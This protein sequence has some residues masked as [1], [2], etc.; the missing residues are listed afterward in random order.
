MN[1]NYFSSNQILPLFIGAIIL[2]FSILFFNSGKTKLGLT[3]LFLGAM[4]LGFFMANL[5]PYL[6]MWDEQYHALVAKNLT[7]D[8]FKP[9]LYVNPLLKYDYKNWTGNHIWMHKQPLFLWQMA[10]SLKLFG[11]NTLAVRLP[12]I[13]LHAI[14]VL[15]IYRIGKISSNEK[16]GFYG[17][18]FFAVAYYPLELIAGHYSTDHNDL[19]FLFYITASFWAWFEYQHTQKKQYLVLIGLFAGCAVLV[20]WLVGLLIYGVWFFTIG[21]S[22][23]RN[24]VKIK[25]YYPLLISIRISLLVFLPWQIYCY[26]QY[27]LEFIHEINYNSQH[28]FK[29]IEG[30]GGDVWFHFNALKDIYGSNVVVGIYLISLVVF[31]VKMNARSYRVAILSAIVITYTFF[32]IAATKMISFCIIVSPFAFLALGSL[33]NTASV[34]LST[35]IKYKKFEFIFSSV[36]LVVVVALIMNVPKIEQYHT[37]WKPNDNC[38]REIELYELEIIKR[39]KHQLGDE[40]YVVFYTAGFRNIQTMFFTNYIAYDFIP[41]KEQI[42]QVESTKYKIAI[43]DDGALPKYIN[44]KN[45]IVKIKR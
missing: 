9:T 44:D 38:H 21:A 14:A 23:K 41:T 18:L 8:I 24:W 5:D 11:M 35:K 16:T 29:V 1:I 12:S 6:I 30:H 7:F 33:V 36:A 15:M 28:L 17:A 31:I 25:S 3:L 13:I 2:I 34:Y 37:N 32:T 39:L 27:P 40:N 19:S 20:K 26:L 42:A 4:A 22:D 43:L 10:L 45:E